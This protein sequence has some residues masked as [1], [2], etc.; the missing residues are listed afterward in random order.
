VSTAVEITPVAGNVIVAALVMHWA[1]IVIDTLRLAVVVAASAFDPLIANPAIMA[2]VVTRLIR[3]SCVG[4][5]SD[6]H[7]YSYALA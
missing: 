7:V 4:A 6:L 1:E 2:I 5:R 3:F